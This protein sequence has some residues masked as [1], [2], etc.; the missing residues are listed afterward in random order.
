MVLDFTTLAIVPFTQL[1]YGYAVAIETLGMIVAFLISFLGYKAFKLTKESKYKYFFYGFLFLALNFLAHVILN[2][3]VRFGYVKFFLEKRYTLYI[4]PLFAGYY[5]FLI[6]LILAYIS[7]AILYSDVKKTKT[8]WLYY[9]WAFVIG[10]YSFRDYVQFNIMAAVPLSFVCML[11]YKKYKENKNKNLLMTFY[12]FLSL[13]L[14]HA[15]TALEPVTSLF[16]V[17]R[18]SILL[19]G[20]VLLFITLIKIHGRKKK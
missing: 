19:I 18:Y 3:L 10:A 20:L 5:F 7:F 12:A 17:V 8:V 15:L 11:I 4:A 9:V 1:F 6:A 2:L 14:F 13:F 16:Y